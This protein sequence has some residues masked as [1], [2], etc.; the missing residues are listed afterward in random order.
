MYIKDVSRPE[1]LSKQRQEVQE[2]DLAVVQ[3][4]KDTPLPSEN[5][6]TMLKFVKIENLC[7]GLYKIFSII[8]KYLSSVRK[9]IQLLELF[10]SLQ[11]A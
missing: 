8:K 11:S 3:P 4:S 10:L 9:K 2:V 7:S 6:N 5:N 1:A